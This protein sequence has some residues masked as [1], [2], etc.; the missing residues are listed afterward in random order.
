LETLRLSSG[1]IAPCGVVGQAWLQELQKEETIRYLLLLE[2]LPER[3]V[4]CSKCANVSCLYGVDRLSDNSIHGYPTR[5]HILELFLPKFQSLHDHW[6]SHK[7]E[8]S[9]PISTDTIRCTAST[10][11]FGCLLLS[12]IRD[13]RL[14]QH[15]ERLEGVLNGLTRFIL[16]HLGGVRQTKALVDSML[17]ALQP[18]LPVGDA[19]E[20]THLFQ[21]IPALWTFFSSVSENLTLPQ[22]I[23]TEIAGAGTD[24]PM[25]L[26]DIFDTKESRSRETGLKNSLARRDLAMAL[27]PAAFNLT[28]SAHLVLV[29][30]MF[31]SKNVATGLPA[32]F[33]A[34]I[35]GMQ[36]TETFLCRQMLKDILQSDLAAGTAD[37]FKLIDHIA[38]ILSSPNYDCC[39]VAIGLGLDALIGSMPAWTGQ[40][41][42]DL[43]GSA[44]QTYDYLI[45]RLLPL[46]RPS[47]NVQIWLA[48]M[49]NELM[50]IQPTYGENRQMPSVRSCLFDIL[51]RGSISVK[52]HVAEHLPSLFGLFV[53]KRHNDIL[54]DVLESLP[55]DPDWAEGIALRL[56]VLGAL[57]SKWPTLIRLC[58]YYILEVPGRLPDSIN[59]ATRCLADVSRAL[60]L[61]NVRNLFQLFASQLLY[62]W[63]ASEPI[64]NIPY[65]IFG[66]SSLKDLVRENQEEITALMTMRNQDDGVNGLAQILGVSVEMLLQLCFSKVI[67][68]SVAHDISVPQ[69]TNA[70]KYVSG[71][72]RIRKR[73]GKDTFFELVHKH[74]ADIVALFF[75]LIDQEEHII[76]KSFA[77]DP[78]FV[79]AAEGLQEIRSTSSSEVALPPNH[80]PAF[81]AKYL[82]SEIEHLCGRT[83]YE[84]TNL[85]TPSL[86]VFIARKIV[87]TIHPALGSLHACAVLRKLRVLVALS[88]PAALRGYPVEMLLHA[89]RPFITDSECANDSIG[90]VQYIL[91][92]S[93]QYLSLRPSFVASVSLTILA[94]L[95]AFMESSPAS[96]TQQSQYRSTLSK[97][98]SFH[99][100]LG[101]YLA[102][103]ETPNLSGDSKVA[104][105]AIFDSVHAF[106][107]IGT[108]ESGTA[109]SELLLELLEDERSGR[110]LLNKAS[111]NLAFSL[112]YSSFQQPESFRSDVLGSDDRAVTYAATVWNLCQDAHISKPLLTWAAKV[113]GRAFA[114]TGHI[115][116]QL[117][118]ESGL[119]RIN[120]IAIL[121]PTQRSSKSCLLQL[122]QALTLEDNRETVGLVEAVLRMILTRPEM[123][124][125]NTEA[126]VCEESLPEPLYK[127]SDWAPYHVPPS[128]L[129]ILQMDPSHDAYTPESI[130]DPCWP[131][132]LSVALV[133]SVPSD[134][135]LFSLQRL[136]R[137][138][139][140]FAEEAFPFIVHLVLSL[141]LD[142]PQ[143]VN[144]QLSK[145]IRSWLLVET[146]ADT[147]HLKLLINTLLYL[148]TQPLPRETSSA[149][150]MH[151]LEVDYSKAAEA[152]V[153]C[154]MF[155]TA[156]LFIEVSLSETTRSLRRS[157]IS[158]STEPHEILSSIFKHID[159][160]DVFYGLQQS[161]SLGSVLERLEYE[162]DG[163]KSL[164]FRGAQYDSSLRR[165]EQSSNLDAQALVKALGMLS[166][167]GLSHSLL[168][169]QQT[170]T[171]DKSSVKRMFQTARRLEQW[172]LPVPT[173]CDNDEVAIYKTFQA[174][175]L[176]ES[177][178]SVQ[179][180][181]DEGLRSTVLALVQATTRA[182]IIHDSLRSLAALTEIDEVLSASNSEEFE[183]MLTRFQNRA[184]W[185]E[186]GK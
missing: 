161:A 104:L 67:A 124:L 10:S 154:G 149:D 123:P 13:S 84:T 179:S 60:N 145:A 39:E 72:A 52:F 80:Q 148:R 49:L 163:L 2:D 94:S 151:W 166:L 146:M 115:H 11:V 101:S 116:T 28:T 129:L 78:R 48:R 142:G 31:R 175:N 88:G 128:D 167:D 157:S 8:E 66:Y 30:A 136:L 59:H 174:A 22:S 62:T 46:R 51:Q 40:A 37:A 182:S 69:S 121:V 169:S 180:A 95:R 68:Y 108:A 99:V 122:L 50:R 105:R 160:P 100:W 130:M 7:T 17:Q 170:I 9:T 18:Y 127:A 168:Q 156:L 134:A 16:V 19:S 152:A 65:Q 119:K 29:S 54:V 96:T 172:D 153:R 114:A 126:V 61:E 177:R 141:Q 139:E 64:D 70:K 71:E 173:T 87:N 155:K 120:E 43:V 106:R 55:S 27:S 110:H 93:S 183:E 125:D 107:S 90:I 150:R 41:D 21:Q 186:T 56:K 83:E 73:L 77:K 3:E 140:G 91:S 33:I 98:Q 38:E 32:E 85:Y 112:L 131:S 117:M 63:L 82:T 53:L 137:D 20:L 164:A 42:E 118:Q 103:Y 45:G 34:Y 109:E 185:M 35:T 5:L 143:T 74:F 133:Q 15:E 171:M 36:P 86:I 147:G 162:N 23:T 81:K 25:E 47:P 92:H 138:A 178:H 76:E 79:Y 4:M 111:R 159:D 144:R 181:I 97:A 184:D 6:E 44:T 75:N 26:D 14:S 57:A 12:L 113:L 158:K 24:D 58:T 102:K 1:G 89:V 135:V 132:T 165:Q 176:A